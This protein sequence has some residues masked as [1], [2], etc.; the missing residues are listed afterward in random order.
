M[1]QLSHKER[2]TQFVSDLVGGTTFD[3]Y[4]VTA[5]SAVSYLAWCI[6]KK[7]TTIF[8]ARTRQE[9]SFF[10]TTVD[11]LL[12][13]NNLLFATTVYANNIPLLV[14]LNVLPII[15]VLVT[16][17]STKKRPRSGHNIVR[18][19]VV[20]LRTLTSKQFLP[21]KPFITVYRAQMMVI[22]CLCIMGV[23]FHVFPRRF[24]KVETW[25]T[26]LMDLGVGSFVFSMGLISARSY[27]RQLYDCKYGYSRT[28]WRSVKNSIP[29]FI[30][31]LIRWIS[32]K[33]VDYHEHVTEYGR[34]WNFFF[35]LACLPV[36]NALLA[37]ITL[38]LSPIVTSILISLAYEYVLIACGGLQFVITG[39][40]DRN[41][42]TANKEGILSLCGYFPIFLNG[43]ALGGCILPVIST[44]GA[45]MSLGMSREKLCKCYAAGKRGVTPLR[46]MLLFSIL[47]QTAY[48]V[49]DTCYAYPVSRRM[50][51][52]L[53]VIWVSAYNCSFL[54]LYGLIEKLVWGDVTVEVITE[55]SS[56]DVETNIDEIVDDASVPTSLVAVN[57]NS[58]VLF[59]ASNLLTG[60]V[61]LTLN[62]LDATPLESMTALFV[63]EA[64]LAGFALAL[65]KAGVVLR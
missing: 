37:P 26:S 58:L 16:S 40:R 19:A 65:Y 59:L 39:E 23:D 31:G 30:L 5:M 47:F 35:T 7:R 14:V 1:E 12:N 34:H 62:T 20:N 9:E 50:A 4:I 64:I 63:Y 41:L 28:L 51:N 36:L 21:F 45:M 27:I 42:F 33:S 60:L 38:R 17:S 22:T 10:A 3:V 25:G 43:L 6:L 54:F 24:A 13:W 49:I 56:V 57:N 18:K 55:E 15:P 8:D 53:Y 61:N 11:F 29:I 32:V 52:I 44:P 48:Y 2:K 46:A